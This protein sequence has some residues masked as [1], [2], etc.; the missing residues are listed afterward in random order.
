M[1]YQNENVVINIISEVSITKCLGHVSWNEDVIINQ[2]SV[3]HEL[4]ASMGMV[5]FEII[6]KGRVVS[7]ENIKHELMSRL[8]SESSALDNDV[9]RRMLEIIL[10]HEGQ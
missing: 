9:Y 1:N 2:D 5:V 4:L 3:G 6:T 8:R 10:L 7:V